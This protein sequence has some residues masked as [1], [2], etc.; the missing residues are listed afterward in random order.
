LHPTGRASTIDRVVSLCEH[1]ELAA[2]PVFQDTF[3][4]SMLFPE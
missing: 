3:V 2:D 1:V 4:E